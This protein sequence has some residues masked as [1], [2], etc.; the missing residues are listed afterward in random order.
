MLF[1]FLILGL[2]FLC[3]GGVGLFYVNVGEHTAVWSSMWVI[4]NLAFGTFLVFGAAILIFLAFF[5][6]EFD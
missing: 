6:A 3:S 4:G 5:N 2:I 1:F